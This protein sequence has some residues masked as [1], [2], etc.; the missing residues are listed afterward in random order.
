MLAKRMSLVVSAGFGLAAASQAHAATYAGN[1]ATGFAGPVGQ[2]RLSI[3]NAT[4]TDPNTAATSPGVNF[5]FTPSSGHPSGLDGNNLVI[6]LSTGAAGL[7]DTQS[8]IDTGTPA[9]SDYGHV[10]ISGYNNFNNG[11]QTNPSHSV[12]AFPSGFQAIYAFSFANAYDG[13]FKLP[14]DGSGLLSYI[15]GAAPVNNNN[16]ITIPLSAIGL[17]PGQSFSFVATYID[18]SSA[19]RSNEAIGGAATLNGTSQDLATAGNPGFNNLITFTSSSSFAT[20]GVPEPATLG[21]AAMGVVFL[22]RRRR[23]A[24]MSR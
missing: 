16:T 4:Y 3:N 21:V 1:G 10:A 7:S 12:I 8:L 9:G 22:S 13:L 19:Y 2:G 24:G 6:Y 20:A 23:T 15:T 14:T 11:G 18:G 17:T 5:T